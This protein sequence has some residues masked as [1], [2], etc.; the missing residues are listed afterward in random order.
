VSKA[1][2]EN[3]QV[4]GTHFKPPRIT[5]MQVVVVGRQ[6]DLLVAI[7]VEINL[8]SLTR[9]FE[10][11]DSAHKRIGMGVLVVELTGF[12]VVEP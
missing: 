3:H 7:T 1:R 2:G 11:Q 12:R 5:V 9:C 4:A 8:V 6:F 10:I